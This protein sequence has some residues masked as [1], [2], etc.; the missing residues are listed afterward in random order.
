M[1][2]ARSYAV[3]IPALDEE[4]ALPHVLDALPCPLDRVTVVDNGSTDR[5]ADVA[6]ELGARVVHEPR[7]GYGRACLAGIGA[8]P[9][10]EVLVFLDADF[11][12]YPDQ[13]TSLLVPV[14]EGRA[15]LVLGVR[16]GA[17]RPWHATLGTRLCV[18]LI[19]GLW[20]TAYR[21][22]GPFR[23]IARPA[24]ERLRMEDQTWGWTIEM[25]VKAA[26]AGLTVVEID[27]PYRDRIGVSKIS[28]SVRGTVKAGARMLAL[29]AGLA[30]TRG[31]R[32][33]PPG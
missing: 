28:G 18:G 6:R 8:N 23:A 11:S 17:G 2:P 4:Q 27:V 21:D 31:R 32:R 1:S 10:A 29:I 15:D 26:E 25:Q 16:H 22:L 19:N 12:D 20:R 9:T 3:I 33:Y 5:T 13:L 7:R 14:F 24:L 30:L